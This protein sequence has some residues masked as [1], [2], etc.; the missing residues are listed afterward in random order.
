[1]SER[2]PNVAEFLKTHPLLAYCTD[3]E[4]KQVYGDP[5]REPVPSVDCAGWRTPLHCKEKV[6]DGG[7]DGTGYCLRCYA[8]REDIQLYR[9]LRKE[10][11]STTQAALMAG[12]TDPAE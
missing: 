7:V 5:P 3:D 12:L 4:I 11:Y 2:D 9:E 6:S 1:M 8:S 10:G